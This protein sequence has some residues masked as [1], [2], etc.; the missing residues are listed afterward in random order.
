MPRFETETGPCF[1]TSRYSCLPA[2]SN[3]PIQI[4]SQ[5][6]SLITAFLCCSS[7]CA[8]MSKCWLN[9]LSLHL[10]KFSWKV[11]KSSR[12]LS[13]FQYELYAS[14]YTVVFLN[15]NGFVQVMLAIYSENQNKPDSSFHMK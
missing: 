2:M 5:T 1:Q 11:S 6:F 12:K 10:R 14:T 13:S 4:E 3:I 8:K 7:S 9:I 15:S